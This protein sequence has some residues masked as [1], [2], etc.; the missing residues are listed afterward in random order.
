M[1]GPLAPWSFGTVGMLLVLLVGCASP[2]SFRTFPSTA[3]RDHPYRVPVLGMEFVPVTVPISPG[4]RVTSPLVLVSRWEVRRADFAAFAKLDTA[5]DFPGYTPTAMDPVVQV[6]WHEAVAFLA[7]LNVT[8][9]PPAGWT[10]RLPTDAEWSAAVG[11]PWEAGATPRSK[12]Q[13]V[14]DHYPWLPHHRAPPAPC[15]GNY[16]DQAFHRARPTDAFIHGYED[17]FAFTA[18]VGSYPPNEFGLY[19]LGGNA[20]EWCQDTLDPAVTAR[21]VRGS[22]WGYWE[23]DRQRSTYRRAHEPNVRRNDLGFRVVLAPDSVTSAPSS[24]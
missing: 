17:G 8:Y 22:S 7:W 21:V 15:M 3:T 20:W 6:T 16:A 19:D 10:F 9:P 23:P 24:R 14:I 18:P 12:S 13:Q 2:S 5:P 11:L 1:S 4:S